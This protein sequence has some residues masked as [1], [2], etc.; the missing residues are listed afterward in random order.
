MEAL[1]WIFPYLGLGL[2]VGFFAGLLGI[3]GGGIMVPLLVMILSAACAYGIR[4][5]YGFDCAHIH[6][7]RIPPS[8]A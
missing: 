7:K 1:Y 2:L 6:V 8:S 4:H 5:V 3:G